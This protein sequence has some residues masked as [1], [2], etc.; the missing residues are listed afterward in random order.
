MKRGILAAAL[1]AVLACGV[2]AGG[3][4]AFASEGV[5]DAML[6]VTGT[7]SVSAVADGC[8]FCGVIET[9][10]DDLE[11]ASARSGEV[12]AAVRSAFERYG[13]VE[14]EHFS[15]YPLRGQGYTATRCLRFYSEQAG[16]AEEMRAALSEAGMTSLDGAVPFCKDDAA[17]RTEALR[18]AVEDAKNKAAQLGAEGRLVRAEEMFCCMSRSVSPSGE[19]TYDATVRAVF[20]RVPQGKERHPATQENQNAA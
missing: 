12:F 1:A 6:V 4:C 10:G 11:T 9:V 7:A 16:K 20:A 18:L 8:T 14:E 3:T 19:V 15:V 13:S 5:G 2:A 17:R